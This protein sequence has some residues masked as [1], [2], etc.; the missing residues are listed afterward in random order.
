MHL[1]THWRL[2]LCARETRV[3]SI[4]LSL[5]AFSFPRLKRPLSR[6]I[7][8]HQTEN[9][10]IKGK[11]EEKC[12]S[13]VTFSTS[14]PKFLRLRYRFGNDYRRASREKRQNCI[15][16]STCLS[17]AFCPVGVSGVLK[18]SLRR[19]CSVRANPARSSAPEED[20]TE[21]LR[22]LC[23]KGGLKKQTKR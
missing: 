11:N 21:R 3:P 16:V 19:V 5:C 15:S 10:E 13:K 17:A 14:Q 8:E 20:T 22:M 9:S 6:T 4:A 2:G 7:E 23:L 18:G 12:P 1:L